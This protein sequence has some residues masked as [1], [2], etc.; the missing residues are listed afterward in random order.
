MAQKQR[1]V[2]H[3]SQNMKLLRVSAESK[4]SQWLYVTGQQRWDMHLIRALLGIGTWSQ[5]SG[6]VRMQGH[7]DI[8]IM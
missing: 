7:T 6:Q 1:C 3:K 2:S 4:I 5:L 8:L